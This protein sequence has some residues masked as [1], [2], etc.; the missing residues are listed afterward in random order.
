MGASAGLYRGQAPAP[1][2]GPECQAREMPSDYETVAQAI[3]YIRRHSGEQ[4]DLAAVEAHVHLSPFHFQRVFRRWAGLSPKRFLQLVTIERAKEVLARSASILDATY[5]VGL[6]SPGR[7]HDLFVTLDAVTPGEFKGQGS[8][9]E[10]LTGVHAS[11]FGYCLV[12][13]TDRGLCG[14]SFHDEAAC[15]AGHAELCTRWPLAS[16]RSAPEQTEPIFRRL[17]GLT[18]D[19][20]AFRVSLFVKGTNFQVKVW[21]ALLQCAPGQLCTY[22]DLA[23]RSGHPGAARAV[24]GALARNPVAFLIPCHRVITA[25]GNHGHYRWGTVRKAAMIGWELARFGAPAA[26]SRPGA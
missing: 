26:E 8:G 21:Q 14:L 12:A 15:A 7:L 19:P 20:P 4:P 2:T 11:P 5:E 25:T 24:G 1:G 16:F 13:M 17:F 6:S 23:E 9:L 22:A 18:V 3:E 10:I